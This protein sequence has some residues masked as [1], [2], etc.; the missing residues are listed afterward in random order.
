MKKTKKMP[1]KELK[2]NVKFK[3][4]DKKL[5]EAYKEIESYAKGVRF[6]IANLLI[7]IIRKLIYKEF[8]ITFLMI[9]TMKRRELG[10]IK[11]WW[12]RN[13]SIRRKRKVAANWEF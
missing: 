11:S 8:T 6:N 5:N 13:I 2:V 3:V 9:P 4:D 1:V 7:W 12:A 10:L